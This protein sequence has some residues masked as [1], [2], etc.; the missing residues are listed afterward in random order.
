MIELVLLVF[1]AGFVMEFIDSFLGG[2][3]GTVLTPLFLII[4]FT[5]PQIVPMILLSEIFTGLIGGTFH[6]SFGNVNRRALMLVGPF[7]MLGTIFA[8]FASIKVDKFVINL[9]IGM[10]VLV[11]GIFMFAR[12]W[13]NRDSSHVSAKRHDKRLPFIG[14][15]IGFNKAI[16]GGGFG[17]I[18]TGGLSWSGYDPKKSVGTTT[19]LEG[20]V[21]VVGF[22]GYWYFSGINAIEW[23]V[24]VPL[25][26]GAVSATFP[27][28][29]ATHKFPTK[30]LGLMVSITITLLGVW[31]LTKLV[32]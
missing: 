9:Y 6:H 25:I 5:V 15:L 3:Y 12:Y 22:M 13:R 11:L 10:L 31:V 28:A 14:G 17:P 29:Y 32:I 30:Y 27:A 20:L 1:L 16:S 26:A 8:L 23:G 4:G 2:G 7:A 21:C 19:L 18:L 24:A